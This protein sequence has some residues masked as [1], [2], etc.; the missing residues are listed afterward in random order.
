MK[1][2]QRIENQKLLIILLA[3]IVTLSIKGKGNFLS[4]ISLYRILDEIT[5]KGILAHRYDCSHDK[6][7]H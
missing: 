3:V 4:I 1:I 6:W 7:F 2:L 5:I